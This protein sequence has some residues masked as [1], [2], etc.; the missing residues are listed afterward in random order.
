MPNTGVDFFYSTFG[1]GTNLEYRRF[2]I[3]F[4]TTTQ[5]AMPSITRI[6]FYLERLA[7]LFVLIG[8]IFQAT[9]NGELIFISLGFISISCVFFI[10]AFQPIEVN[11]E[12]A[13]SLEQQQSFNQLLGLV[14]LPK[15]LGISMSIAT[16]GVMYYFLEM[17]GSKMMLTLGG[18]TTLVSTFLLLILRFSTLKE[19]EGVTQRLYR[20]VVVLIMVGLIAMIS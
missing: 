11:E 4:V 18:M 20:A 5:P 9:G 15:V 7:I 16:I 10:G 19:V 14:I 6:L 8:A 13:K 2:I 1:Q 17:E 12:E 3:S